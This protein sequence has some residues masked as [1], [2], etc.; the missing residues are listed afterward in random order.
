MNLHDPIRY[1]PHGDWGLWIVTSL[2]A[3]AYLLT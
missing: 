1:S 3:L 2:V